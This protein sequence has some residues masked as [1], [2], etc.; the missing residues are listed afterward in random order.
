MKS[1]TIKFI[2]LFS[3]IALAGLIISQA[4]W[5][6]WA[7]NLSEKHFENRAYGALHGAV[8][9][10]IASKKQF[11]DTLCGT[12]HYQNIKTL[13]PQKLLDSLLNKHIHYNK[14]DNSFEFAVIQ[15]HND[16][17]V[18]HTNGFY[19]NCPKEKVFKRC[20]T[21]LYNKESFHIELIF[22]ASEKSMMGDIW[23]WLTLSAIFI[24]IIAFCFGFIVFAVFRHKK[25]SEM[26][27]DFINNMTH[28][29]KT[30]IST[31][32][33]ASE[34]L[35]NVNSEVH[36]EKVNRYAKIIQEENRR[37]QSQVEQVLRMSRLDKNEYEL[38]K[39]E[40]DIHELVQNAIHNLC[41]DLGNKSVD[42]KYKLD[43]KKFNIIA[44]PIHVTNIVKNLVENACKY[45]IGDPQ[46]ELSTTNVPEGIVISVE[47]NGIGISTDKQKLIFDKFYRVP[48]GDVHNVKGTGIGLYYVKV[49][50]EAHNG[51]VNVRSE[52]NKGARFD[53]FLPFQ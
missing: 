7:I 37:M 8:Q 39:E 21:C 33:L 4:F 53:V 20:L 11:A 40:T 14:I 47:D 50:V 52:P 44:D 38:N 9:E 30:P 22:P 13:V 25:L 10:I 43:A 16:S 2:I 15:S 26:K 17:V 29:F 19:L 12:N 35:V 49:M 1:R 42:I 48:T 24:L 28:E 3:A 5:I 23:T 32:S 6:R 31:I 34:I 46:I 18:Y 36:L 45:C 51:K 41:L 27:T